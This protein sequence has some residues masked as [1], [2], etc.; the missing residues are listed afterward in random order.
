[1][2]AR[3]LACALG[4]LLALLACSCKAESTHKTLLD[5]SLVRKENGRIVVTGRAAV[6][7]GVWVYVETVADPGG[8]NG[9]AAEAYPVESGIFTAV[10]PFSAPLVYRA[11]IVLSPALNPDL[12]DFLSAQPQDPGSIMRS[13][14]QGAELIFRID[15][16]FGSDADQKGFADKIINE[17]EKF[18]KVL[19]KDFREIQSDDWQRRMP[20]LLARYNADAPQRLYLYTPALV[21]RFVKAR[22]GLDSVFRLRLKSL[23]GSAGH[24][25]A[26]KKSMEKIQRQLEQAAEDIQALKDKTHK[27]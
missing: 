20:D 17:A 8:L 4:C 19:S 7:D 11:E 3:T 22:K 24:A 6:P 5:A 26:L 2:N 21:N 9:V 23:Q 13:T 25:E 27:R 18:L 1:M 15:A 16:T 10:T 14:K 12:G